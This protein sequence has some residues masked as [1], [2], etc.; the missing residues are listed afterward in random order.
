MEE[1]IKADQV[2]LDSAAATRD[3]A[4]AFLADQA[5]AAGI[6]DDAQAV[7][8]AYLAREQEGPTVMTEGFALPH[9]KSESV[10]R[11]GVF[12]V[13]FAEPITDW[14]ATQGPVDVAIALAIPKEEAATTHLRLLSQLALALMQ[15][16]FREHIAEAADAESIAAVINE[17]LAE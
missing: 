7:L 2:V 10:T 9:A 17:K 8:D 11:P 5:V 1:F 3:E 6:A 14:D 12:V 13:R 4:L 16:D 15:P